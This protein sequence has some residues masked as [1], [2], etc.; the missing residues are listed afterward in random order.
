[1]RILQGK[2]EGFMNNGYSSYLGG[3][4]LII[5]FFIGVL[6]ITLV[7]R[8]KGKVIYTPIN[9]GSVSVFFDEEDN[10]I[11]IP[12]KKD[13]FGMG[14]ATSGVLVLDK[15]LKLQKL[16]EMLRTAMLYYSRAE[17][18]TD[19]EIMSRLGYQNWKDFSEGKRSIAVH[20]REGTGLVFNSTSRKKDGAYDFNLNGNELVMPA[21]ADDTSLGRA[22]LYLLPRCRS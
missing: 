2:R 6:G 1:V 7:K 20:F 14:R 3:I 22:L 10:A 17:I 9:C 8:K 5:A 19:K 18:C 15:V 16:G 12:Y 11:F 13:R 21:D 4:V